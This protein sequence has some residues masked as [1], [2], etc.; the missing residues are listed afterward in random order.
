[1]KKPSASWLESRAES[2]NRKSIDR[3]ASRAR[4]RLRSMQRMYRC[5]GLLLAGSA[6]RV[7]VLGVEEVR[8]VSLLRRAVAQDEFL[9]HLPR[10]VVG[11]LNGWRL[12]E[13]GARSDERAGHPPV[14]G[15]AARSDGVDH[16]ASGV[17]R[18]PDLQLE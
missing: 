17:G 3:S 2:R 13:V 4:R 16:D 14:E 11:E 12:H 18:V 7:G 8:P 9:D 1:W 10:R 5:G 15:E 6:V